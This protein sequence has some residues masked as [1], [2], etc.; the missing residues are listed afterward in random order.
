MNKNYAIIAVVVIIIGAAGYLYWQN[1]QQQQAVIEQQ[2]AERRAKWE[3][4]SRTMYLGCVGGEF[5]PG[6]QNLGSGRR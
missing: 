3:E 2:L 1:Q 4:W 6:V 5:H